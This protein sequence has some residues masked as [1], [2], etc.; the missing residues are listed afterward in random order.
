MTTHNNQYTLGKEK[1]ESEIEK[2]IIGNN[3]QKQK[4][5]NNIKKLKEVIKENVI[6]E[7]Q[8]VPDSELTP[9]EISKIKKIAID[10]GEYG[11]FG[12]SIS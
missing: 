8:V 6:A 12:C 11:L 1:L 2:V 4:Q 5:D 9:E 7:N 3:T 10:G